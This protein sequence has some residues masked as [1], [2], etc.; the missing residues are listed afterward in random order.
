MDQ[1]LAG[2][3]SEAIESLV[4]YCQA[5]QWAGYDPYDAL[6]SKV[7][8]SAPFYRSKF[9]RIAF[10]QAMK[11]SPVNLRPLLGVPREQNPKA[12]ALFASALLK[13]SDREDEAKD[14]VQLLLKAKSAGRPYACWGYNFAWQN[15]VT[16]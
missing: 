10:T 5:N 4:H 14:V 16:F 15:R 11:R 3:L 9:C 7:F 2:N 8:K 12:L 13:L 1:S 6:N